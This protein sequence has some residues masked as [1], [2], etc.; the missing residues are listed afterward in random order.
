MKS[1]MYIENGFYS[2]KEYIII[3]ELENVVALMETETQTI[4]WET[5]NTVDRKYK[6]KVSKE[7]K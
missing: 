1:K 5:R 7:N 4:I 3:E 2:G 6:E